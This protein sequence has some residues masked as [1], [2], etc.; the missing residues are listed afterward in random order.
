MS[1]YIYTTCIQK[2]YFILLTIR[3][4]KDRYNI[5]EALLPKF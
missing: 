3:N 2:A 4:N 1:D 5:K